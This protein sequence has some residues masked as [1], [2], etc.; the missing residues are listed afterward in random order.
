MSDTN[1]VRTEMLPPVA[2]PVS[3]RGVVRWLREN[4]FSGPLNTI[5][6]LLAVA[7]LYY[8]IKA[9][10]PW[11]LNGVW[12]ATSLRECREIVA[13]SAGPDAT[14]ACWAVIRERWHQFLFGF[15]LPELWWRP[16]LCFALLFVA[17]AP[18]L[19]S[20]SRRNIAL[21]IG[22]V[23]ALLA[24]CLLLLDTVVLHLVVS[25][26]VMLALLVV[27][28]TAPR[29]LLWVTLLYPFF[30]VWLL[31]GGAIWGPVLTL[32]GAERQSWLHSISSQHVAALPVG[33]ADV[34]DCDARP[35]VRGDG[36]IGVL[37][38]VRVFRRD[39]GAAD[40]MAAP[41]AAIERQEQSFGE[42]DPLYSEIVDFVDS[43]RQQRPPKVT[44]RAGRR[45]LEAVQRITE[46]TR[47][48]S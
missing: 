5:L 18:V 43:V 13:A 38:E 31:W 48:I 17:L 4:L 27:A 40:P 2:P 12:N 19:Y 28:W 46:A 26:G 1:F 42:A 21:L 6:S 3:Q 25:V 16:M 9:S 30:A 44:G 22:A 23:T 10:L 11:W 32:A 33:V 37:D 35:G 39:L 8:L 24:L 20:D 34:P 29:K 41:E 47:L 14:G 45:A 7:A 36:G 15:Y